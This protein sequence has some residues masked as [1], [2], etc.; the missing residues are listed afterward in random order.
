MFIDPEV[1]SEI[2]LEGPVIGGRL[3]TGH[4]LRAYRPLRLRPRDAVLHP[5]GATSSE[6]K[7]DLWLDINPASGT[8][9]LEHAWPADGRLLP[10]LPG[11]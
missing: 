8:V 11:P 5:T 9:D 1:V 6:R 10:P 4:R 3:G 2:S 7:Q